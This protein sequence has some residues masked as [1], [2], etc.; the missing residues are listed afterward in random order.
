MATSTRRPAALLGY[1][2][3]VLFP[4]IFFG[5]VEG[6]LRLLDL[7][8]PD[9][10]PD[11]F[12]GL[13]ESHRVFR[14]D[15][16]GDVY[17]IDRDRARSFNVQRF[18]ARKPTGTVRIFCLGG[19][20][21]YGYPFG[22]PVAFSRWIEEGCRR[23]WPDES[24]EV[25]N[26]SGMS[27]GSFRLRALVTEILDYE[28]DLIILYSGHNEFIE[29]DFYIQSGAT[30]LMGVRSV[31]GNLHLYT[32]LKSW[33]HPDRPPE[34]ADAGGF[35]QF[36]LHVTRRENIGWTDEER[37]RVIAKYAENIEAIVARLEDEGVPLLM[38]TPAPNESHW[39]PEHSRVSPDLPAETM[40]AWSN[41][42]GQGVRRQSDGETSA[43]IESFQAALRI[44]DRFAELHYRLGQCLEAEGRYDEA[45]EAYRRALD[46]DEVPIR[47]TPPQ[48]EALADIARRRHPYYA[49]AWSA[50]GRI[51][52]HGILGDELFWDY[53]HPT[54]RGHQQIAALACSV[55]TRTGL[56]GAP[57]AP[58]PWQRDAPV[59]AWD[60][61]ARAHLGFTAPDSF[62][63]VPLPKAADGLWWLGNCADRQGDRLQAVR[64]Y[65]QSLQADPD[66]P[67]SLIGLAIARSLGGDQET[68]I[69]LTQQAIA[70]YERARMIPMVLRARAELGVFYARADQMEDAAREFREVLRRNPT[71][72]KA[73]ANLAR[74]LIALERLDEALAVLEDG[75]ARLP[76]ERGLHRELGRVHRL[77]GRPREAIAA[78]EAELRLSPGD[79]GLHVLLADLYEQVGE[80]AAAA[81]HLEACLRL[82][83]DNVEVA[84]K[85]AAL[86]E[87]LGRPSE[88]ARV[89]PDSP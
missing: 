89:R 10:T 68:A 15:A 32:M 57:Q 70:V 34:A 51:A 83:P 84:R 62:D 6:A 58:G 86:Y 33:I 19:S 61:D 42:Y 26:A 71:Q 75:I 69:E 80:K 35:D 3:M 7:Y 72:P 82:D 20:A 56:L 39:R 48:R 11:P 18:A 40:T 36:G 17:A 37:E 9:D 2:L 52:T 30:R 49:D 66:H 81:D 41:A 64:W 28:P 65:E 38:M 67:G 79:P 24:F 5:L 22:A 73:H 43:A 47:I 78:Y 12:I 14:L 76:G 31:L 16:S 8:A 1:A 88:A 50:L 21:A 63:L 46:R 27:Y 85:L 4:L 55:I 13:L 74:A 87:S 29:K 59:H 60:A 25:I 54:I 53:C 44:D 23:L 45:R 77:A